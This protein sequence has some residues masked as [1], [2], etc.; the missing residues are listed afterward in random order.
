MTNP[1]NSIVDALDNIADELNSDPNN[2]YGMTK[3]DEL[4]HIDYQLSR[5][6][7]SLELLVKHFIDNK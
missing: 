3:G 5:I 2:S 1:F 6:A 4:H 7:D